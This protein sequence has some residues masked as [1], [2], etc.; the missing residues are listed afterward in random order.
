MEIVY[1]TDNVQFGKILRFR[2]PLHIPFEHIYIL[3]NRIIEAEKPCSRFIDNNTGAVGHPRRVESAALHDFHTHGLQVVVVDFPALH[4]HRI[5]LVEAAYFGKHVVAAIGRNRQ[6]PGYGSALHTRLFQHFFFQVINFIT[7]RVC[8]IENDHL[9][10]VEAQFFVLNVIQLLEYQQRRNNERY[11]HGKLENHQRTAELPAPAHAGDLAFQHPDGIECRQEKCRITACQYSYQ[12][13]AAGQGGPEQGT[14]PGHLKVDPR[15]VAVP[16]HGHCSDADGYSHRESGN[17][18]RFAQE[19]ADQRAA[20]AAEYFTHPYFLG[21]PRRTG[22]RKV[23]KIDAGDQQ[24][25]GCNGAEYPH[26]PNTA[27]GAQFDIEIGIQVNIGQFLYRK[28]YI[29][30]RFFYFRNGSAQHLLR[31][32]G[33]FFVGKDGKFFPEI[34]QVG[35]FL[36]QEIGLEIIV[37]SPERRVVFYLIVASHRKQHVGFEMGIGRQ[38]FVHRSHLPALPVFENQKLSQGHLRSGKIA[39]GPAAGNG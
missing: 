8:I 29:L 24:D 27:V 15:Q 6:K 23:H 14:A 20:T 5:I 17:N 19:L 2:G 32:D 7:Q 26:V 22:R 10:F 38:V 34:F 33:Y 3:A 39:L 13:A 35:T 28:M 30:A 4:A 11:G 18:H 31:R 16:G 9:I 1:H 25:K 36:Q 37:G 21:P 12:G